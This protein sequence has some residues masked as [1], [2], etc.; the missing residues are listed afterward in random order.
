MPGLNEHQK[1]HL[2]RLGHGLKPVVRTGNAGLTDAVLAELDVALRDH[3]LVKVK[4]VA[5]DRNQRRQYVEQLIEA[6]GAELVQ[7]I[8]H[9]VLVYRPNPDKRDPIALP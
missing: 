4:L 8:G 2:R 1:R 9:M 7:S 5:N 6:T 3:E